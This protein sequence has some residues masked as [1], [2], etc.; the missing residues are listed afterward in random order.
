MFWGEWRTTLMPLR[1]A[2]FSQVSFWIVYIKLSTKIE[3]NLNKTEIKQFY[4]GQN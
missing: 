2:V 4:F 3:K 1:G